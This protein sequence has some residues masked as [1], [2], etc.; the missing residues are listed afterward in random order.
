MGL[1]DSVLG[2]LSQGGSGS[3][4]NPL[5]EAVLSMVNNP[6]T[7]GLA[8]LLQKFQEHGLG[9]V[10]D[11]WVSTGKNLPI[12]P[13][14]LQNALGSGELGSLAEKLG[15]STGDVS[16]QLADLLPGVV[17]KLTPNGQVPDMGSLGDLLGSLT[18]RLG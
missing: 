7:G 12:S 11:S 1:L 15:M 3:G 9:N 18:K 2:S 6:Q 4:G 14:Q 17:D 13:D 16:S 5:L 8:G 10:A